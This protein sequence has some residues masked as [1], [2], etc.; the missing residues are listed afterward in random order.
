[1]ADA[2]FGSIPVVGDDGCHLVGIV[3]DRDI[4]LRSIAQNKDPMN[5]RAGDVMSRQVFSVGPDTDLDELC[6][7]MEEHQVRRVPVVDDNGACIG[8]VA[9]A[10]IARRAPEDA[11]AEVV[12]D[13]SQPS[14]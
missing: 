13:I 2:D 10:D 8:I 3:T 12:K 5:M 1:M 9:Q 7:L 6:R 4:V 11:T 14:S